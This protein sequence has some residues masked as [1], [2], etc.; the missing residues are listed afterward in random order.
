MSSESIDPLKQ[1][2]D[3]AT[4]EGAAPT[5]DDKRLRRYLES[6]DRHAKAFYDLIETMEPDVEARERVRG[7]FDSVFEGGLILVRNKGKVFAE[8]KILPSAKKDVVSQADMEAQAAIFANLEKRFDGE[9]NFFL[10]E[11]GSTGNPQAE[12]VFVVDSLDGTRAYLMGYGDY[13]VS[14]AH[15]QDGVT[16][17]ALVYAP[18]RG[19]V[20]FGYQGKSFHVTED[21]AREVAVTPRPF[22]ES[23]LYTDFSDVAE[24]PETDAS[25]FRFWQEIRRDGVPFK[26]VRY[27]SAAFGVP[28]TVTK[29]GNVFIG[30]D[31]ERV[32]VAAAAYFAVSAGS[33]VWTSITKGRPGFILVTNGQPETDQ[34][35]LAMLQRFFPE[36]AASTR[37]VEKGKPMFE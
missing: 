7:I 13:S 27:N 5:T 17:V 15:E 9:H 22:G 8:E 20:F 21:G 25:M 6:R 1:V 10:G 16:D 3:A 12:S 2:D 24:S 19:E 29:Q 36:E 34:K 28:D 14:L 4:V 32:D 31:L 35:F 37:P 26:D 18:E 11:E 33:R 30:F 23:V